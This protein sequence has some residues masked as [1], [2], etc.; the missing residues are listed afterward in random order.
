MTTSWLD[1]YYAPGTKVVACDD[2]FNMREA[3][4][5]AHTIN[6]TPNYV[7]PVDGIRVRFDDS[8]NGYMDY[9]VSFLTEN[10][11]GNSLVLPM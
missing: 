6:T 11:T 10:G 9:D 4:I 3:T 1:K 8:E 2:F 7:N 5:I